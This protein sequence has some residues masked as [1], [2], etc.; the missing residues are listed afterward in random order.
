MKIRKGIFGPVRLTGCIV[1]IK[2]RI[3]FS[4]FFDAQSKISNEHTAGIVE[5]N[6]GN[7]WV[8]TYSAIVKINPGKK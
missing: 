6:K 8:C 7:L 2:K 4:P 3:I 5:D 1:I